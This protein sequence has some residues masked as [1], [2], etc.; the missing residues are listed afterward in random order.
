MTRSSGAARSRRGEGGTLTA[1]GGT[2]VREGLERGAPETGVRL[3]PLSVV[4]DGGDVL[5]GRPDTGRF[6]SVPPVGGVVVRAL[7]AGAAAG[8]GTVAHRQL[9]RTQQ[10]DL[11]A[12][13]PARIPGT[14]RGRAAAGFLQT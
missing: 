3:G 1:G 14:C 12:P 11:Q 4:D 13:P 8:Q 6:I 7:L 2:P 10:S 9:H 5:V